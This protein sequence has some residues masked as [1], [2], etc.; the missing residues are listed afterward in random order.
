ME[1]VGAGDL[2]T[3]LSWERQLRVH[4]LQSPRRLRLALPG[5]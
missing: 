5:A 4:L 1:L 3:L 2:L